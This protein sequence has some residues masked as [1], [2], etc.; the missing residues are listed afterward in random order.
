VS[1]LP[2]ILVIDDLFGT[3]VH[4]ENRDR[5]AFC[6]RLGLQDVTGDLT[7]ESIQQPLAEAVFV[8]GQRIANKAVENDLDGALD[9]ARK[10]A[11][12]FPRWALILL[13]MHF[14]TGDLVDGVP[15]GRDSDFDPSRY[16]GLTIQRELRRDPL[17]NKFPVVI[18]SS[19][20]RSDI[21]QQFSDFG[22][23]DFKD[24]SALS[25]KDLAELL[26]DY[27]LLEDDVFAGRSLPLQ[28][29]LLLARRRAKFGNDNIV[30]LG[31]TGTGKE[32]LAAY[33]HRKSGRS[34]HYV[35]LFTQGVP[36]TLVEDRLFGHE[37]G[38][39]AGATQPAPGAAE[40]AVKGTLFIDEFGDIPIG[41]QAKLLRLLDKNIREVQRLGSQQAKKLDLQVIM[42]SNRLDLF[43]A[44]DFRK[45]L[46]FR[47]KIGDAI[48]IPPLRERREDIP[49]LAEYFLRKFE[50]QFEA[51]KRTTSADAMDLLTKYDWPGNVRELEK[52]I[53]RAVFDYQGIRVLSASHLK[54]TTEASKGRLHGTAK[55]SDR[56][57][58]IQEK[59]PNKTEPTTLSD[60][61][62]LL[63]A[64]SVDKL[65]PAEVSGSLPKVEDAAARLLLSLLKSALNMTKRVTPDTPEGRLSIHPAIKLLTGDTHISA[66]KSADV[67]KRITSL[68]PKTHEVVM[69]D[70]VLKDALEV[71]LRLRPRMSKKRSAADSGA[72]TI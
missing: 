21:E 59:A 28:Q 48:T 11:E 51:E 32:W 60:I 58:L 29:C 57:T 2:R 13:D 68:S 44:D 45:D 55:S 9:K 71:A 6:F 63:S 30:I 33:V 27:A 4:G 36:E 43:E 14:K 24:K 56:A 10:G 65:G 52:V 38:A 69:A 15:K 41:V 26:D 18:L 64:F 46:L 34:G 72:R 37:K 17:L 39:F 8:S 19:M 40:T 70:P 61:T 66:S 54:L 49:V 12:S 16:F 20:N 5:E 50:Y 35:P 3:S 62:A 53:E 47:A 67:I 42:A 25:R 31:E 7:P 22:A 1:G 23:S